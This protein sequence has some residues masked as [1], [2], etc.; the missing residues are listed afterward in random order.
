MYS[1][2]P[3]VELL[4]HRDGTALA[5]YLDEPLGGRYPADGLAGD[6]LQPT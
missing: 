6:D 2:R 4:V 3:A 1:N 5:A